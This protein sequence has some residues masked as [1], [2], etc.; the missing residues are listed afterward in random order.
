MINLSQVKE[1]SL[2]L[3]PFCGTGTILIEPS[4]LKINSVGVDIDV[5]VDISNTLR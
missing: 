5:G 4:Y 3:D 1:G 2:L